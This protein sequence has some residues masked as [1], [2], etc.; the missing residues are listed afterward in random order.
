GF[1]GTANWRWYVR[2]FLT[3]ADALWVAVG[4]LGLLTILWRD[5]R[6]GCPATGTAPES[7]SAGSRF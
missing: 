6:I 4:S 2:I 5:W 3:S 1:E 7:G